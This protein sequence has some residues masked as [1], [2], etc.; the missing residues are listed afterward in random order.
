[1]ADISI[2]AASVVLVSGVPMTG[3]AG[4]TIAA[5]KPVYL[6]DSD[7]RWWLAQRDGTQEEAGGTGGV[8]GKLGI[9]LNSAS[10]GQPIDVAGPGCDVTIGGTVAVGEIIR[11]SG[12]AGGLNS[13]DAAGSG[14]FDSVVAIGKSTTRVR[15]IGHAAEAAK[16]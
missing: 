6:K 16:A 2:T 11:L 10:A 5:G 4:E 9:A 3:T 1:M 7:G 13:A 15:V 8:N 14:H 12:T